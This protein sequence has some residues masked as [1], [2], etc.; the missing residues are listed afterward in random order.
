ML[1][2]VDLGNQLEK[3]VANLVESGRCNSKSEVMREGIRLIQEREARH[4]ALALAC[5]NGRP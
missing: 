4:R 1:I 3:F 5:F 2:S